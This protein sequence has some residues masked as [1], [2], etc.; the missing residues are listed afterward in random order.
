MTHYPITPVAKPRMT[1]RDR[2]KKRP[3]VVRYRQFCDECRAAGIAIGG[4][5][6]VTFWI[7]MPK[8]WSEKRKAAQDGQPHRQKPDV[9]NL[10]KGLLDLLDDDSGVWRI[11]AE[12]RWARAG[13]ITI[14]DFK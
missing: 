5:L 9:D 6:E 14:H 3:C 12:K 13:A 2:W 1:Q 11:T 8:S 4:T 10:C 7:P